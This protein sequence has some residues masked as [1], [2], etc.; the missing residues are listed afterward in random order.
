MGQVLAEYTH[1]VRHHFRSELDN[2]LISE[3]VRLLNE[4]VDPA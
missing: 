2:F 4:A 1:I 3:L